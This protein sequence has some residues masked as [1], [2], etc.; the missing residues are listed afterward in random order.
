ME[1]LPGGLIVLGAAPEALRN[2]DVH[3]KF[4]QSS[5]FLYLTG[6]EEPGYALL[7]DP[8]RKREILFVPKL[9]QEHAVWLGHI[10]S[11]EEAA[12]RFGFKDVR[13]RSALPKAVAAAKKGYREIYAA[14]EIAPEIR[15][16]AG[17]AGLRPK[18]IEEALSELRAV[19][20]AAEIELLREA[21]QVTAQGHL[22]A[23]RA[24]RP[25]MREYQ[26]QA[27]LERE[28][29]RGGLAH[30]GYS[31]IVAAGRNSAVL[32]Y[33]RNSARILDGDLL[34]VDAG[35]E[36][37][38][39]TADVTRTFPVRGR[40]SPRQREIYELVLSAQKECI[41]RSVPGITS[42]E[43]HRHSCLVLGQG[44]LDLGLAKGT[45]EELVETEAIRVFYPHGLTHMLGLDV[46]DVQGG[47]KRRVPPSKGTKKLR[48]NARLEPGFVITMEPGLYFVPALLDDPKVRRKHKGR[49]NFEKAGA[50]KNFGGIRIEDDIC[51]QPSGPPLNLTIAP[52]EIADVEAACG[53]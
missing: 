10:P 46:H 11:R 4:R 25:G 37:R 20:S 49:I 44:L 53:R 38:G 16:A 17:R 19:K 21:N 1:R 28:F 2:G 8:R 52:K 40:F 39:Y 35:A 3:Y 51:V 15:E 18:A 7:L 26:V 36:C 43:L 47:R 30:M 32:H 33:H 12:A 24:A 29:L 6:V 48:F 41:A 5:H 45:A 9:T 23:M 22:A 27:E 50:Y 34:L 13:Y 31:S 14:K 42:G